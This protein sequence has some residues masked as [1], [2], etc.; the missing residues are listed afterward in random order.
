MNKLN[1]FTYENTNKNNEILFVKKKCI[2][3]KITANIS[4]AARLMGEGV[5][6]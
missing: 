6:V 3:L 4:L 5:S 2:L 1:K